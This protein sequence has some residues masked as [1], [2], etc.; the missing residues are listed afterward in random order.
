MSAKGILK[1]ILPPTLVEMLRHIRRGPQENGSA[2]KAASSPE[3]EHLADGWPKDISEIGW[4]VPSIAAT[5]RGKW[6]SFVESV[7]GPGPLGVSHEAQAGSGRENQWAH[8]LI[9]SY[10]YVLTLASRNRNRI[11]MLDWGGGIGHYFALNKALLPDVT[12]DYFCEDV[13]VLCEVGRSL[14]PEAVFYDQPGGSFAQ[15]YDLVVA[16]SSLWCVENWK[17]T[18]AQLVSASK[19]YVYITRMVFVASSPSFVAVQRPWAYGYLTE[20]PVWILNRDDFVNEAEKNGVSLVREFFFGAGPQIHNA[21]ASGHFRGF[22][23]KR[24]TMFE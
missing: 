6:A 24:A 13:P 23:F 4:N 5:Q 12:V 17:Q 22:L 21:P 16:G 1:R 11:S 9:M 3:W 7:S 15:K 2:E 19:G 10:A 14:L 18:L 8:N 20:Y